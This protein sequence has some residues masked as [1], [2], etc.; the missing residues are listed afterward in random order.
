MGVVYG[1]GLFC[2][3][4]SKT[5]IEEREQPQAE[6]RGGREGGE[7]EKEKEEVD[8]PTKVTASETD[9]QVMTIK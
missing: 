8:S 4:N 6:E 1:R 2:V 7:E 5:S 9:E 3:A